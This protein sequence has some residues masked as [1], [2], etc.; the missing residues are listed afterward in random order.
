MV[1]LL[2]LLLPLP[3]L[4]LVFS[5]LCLNGIPAICLHFFSFLLAAIISPA[6]YRHLLLQSQCFPAPENLSGNFV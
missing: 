5:R 4:W 3:R 1:L 6:F 2:L